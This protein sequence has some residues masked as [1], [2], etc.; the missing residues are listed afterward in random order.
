MRTSGVL[1]NYLRP[2]AALPTHWSPLAPSLTHENTPE[3]LTSH[4]RLEADSAQRLCIST[5]SR[6]E[7][8][9]EATV[10]SRLRHSGPPRQFNWMRVSLSI[11][12]GLRLVPRNL[13]TV[14]ANK[15]RPTQVAAP[16]PR[17]RLA[18]QG[19]CSAS[20]SPCPE[21]QQGAER[22]REP[23]RS[24]AA[25]PATVPPRPGPPASFRERPRVWRPNGGTTTWPGGCHA[26]TPSTCTWVSDADGTG[27]GGSTEKRFSQK[28]KLQRGPGALT[29]PPKN[30][31]SEDNT[32]RCPS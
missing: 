32:F 13:N 23:R 26:S 20:P 14:S 4:L 28:R 8:T 9:C 17:H 21:E 3:G 30:N 24:R 2:T 6:I 5:R 18:L 27:L 7:S 19:P 16:S 1:I 12:A 11:P 22:P 29:Q 10:G 25:A 15:T 31:F